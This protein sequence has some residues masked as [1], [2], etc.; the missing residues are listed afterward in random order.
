LF[1]LLQL[2]WRLAKFLQS[3]KIWNWGL[4]LFH[5]NTSCNSLH[6]T[7]TNF[8][9]KISFR[10]FSA[11]ILPQGQL[12]FKNITV[13]VS[14]CTFFYLV[15]RQLKWGLVCHASK[16]EMLLSWQENL[17]VWMTRQHF[18]RALGFEKLVFYCNQNCWY[19]AVCCCIL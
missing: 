2:F 13:T 12:Y 10:W 18:Y 19:S 1:A 8:L 5:A 15:G 6:K 7:L 4:H 11:P 17:L 14:T 9:P 16:T 3:E